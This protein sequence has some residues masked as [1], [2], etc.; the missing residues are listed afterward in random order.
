MNEYTA[1]L[2]IE[3]YLD[4]H[5]EWITVRKMLK[6]LK[7]DYNTG[8]IILQGME[9]N[10]TVEVEYYAKRKRTDGTDK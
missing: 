8:Q 5:D 3:K 7:I 10:G 1:R 9:H 4:E 2:R 6:K